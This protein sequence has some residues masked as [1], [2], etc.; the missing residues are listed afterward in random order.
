MARYSDA[1]IIQIIQKSARRVNRELCLVGTSDE[2]SVDASGNLSPTDPDIYDIVLLQA[3]CMIMQIDM[4]NDF[5]AAADG[6]GGG[7]YVRDGEQAM[8][9]RGEVASRANARTDY[10]N[11]KYNPCA[12]L[13]RAIL[14]EKLVRCGNPVDI[15]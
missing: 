3:E 11:S 9:T 2:I 4:N 5:T 13:Q 12:E 14:S 7:Y 6:A 15:W 10:L 1:Q 8:D